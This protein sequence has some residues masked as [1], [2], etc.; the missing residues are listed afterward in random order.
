MSKGKL[1]NPSNE[2]WE[3]HYNNALNLYQEG[4]FDMAA[5]HLHMV[6]DSHPTH[7]GPHKLLVQCLLMIGQYNEALEQLETSAAYLDEDDRYFW[8][9]MCYLEGKDLERARDNFER[10]IAMTPDYPYA[11][12]KLAEILRQSG[13][14]EGALKHLERYYRLFPG[15]IE[16]QFV[17]AE[18]HSALGQYDKAMPLYRNVYL[19][20]PQHSEALNRWLALQMQV[21]MA[22]KAQ[23][24]PGEIMQSI[25]DLA[26]AHPQLKTDLSIK[27][28]YIFEYLD[29]IEEVRKC[30]S[31]AL[32]DPGL[33]DSAG[34]TMRFALLY[35]LMPRSLKELKRNHHYLQK[36]LKKLYQMKPQEPLVLEDLSNVGVY[37]DSASALTGLVYQNVDVL[38]L[39][40]Q[41]AEL[42]QAILPP[43]ETLE[44]PA[45]PRPR[46]VFLL[47]SNSS[48]RAFMLNLLRYF[49][50]DQ[51]EIVLL[52]FPED[53][54]RTSLEQLCPDFTHI[55]LPHEVR[56]HVQVL[57][58]L[59]PDL[60]FFSE[61]YTDRKAQTLLSFFR[62]APVQVTS[63]LSSGSSGSNTMDYYLSSSLLEQENEPQ[64]FYS[65][66]LKLIDEIPGVMK[67][68]VRLAA[69]PERS[70]YGLP[71]QGALY[72][73]TH[74]LYK[75]HPDFDHVLARILET[76]PTG[77]VVVQQRPDTG[78]IIQRLL[79]R[80]EA[81]YPEVMPRIWVLPL[82]Q[83]DDYLGLLQIA[84][85]M[86]DPF[87]FGG[88]TTSYEALAMGLPVVTWPGERLHGRI[89]L[90]Y[91]RK[92]QILD[93]IAYNPENYVELAV[94]LATDDN[95]RLLVRQRIQERVA[96]LFDHR[97]SAEALF[98]CLL[99]LAQSKMTPYMPAEPVADEA[100][101]EQDD[102][103]T[104][105]D[106][107]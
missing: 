107:G 11:E 17:Q 78:N 71:E 1:I 28:A 38:P 58:E 87:Y 86:L 23:H 105:G 66:I 36:G 54:M 85:V 67:R 9:G 57:R 68:P 51:A 37:L 92:M 55:S 32:E 5:L 13:D 46:M 21:H 95:L 42:M 80:I 70:E 7:P 40:K 89:T 64:R 97:A 101:D 16:S 79:A 63:W 27:S 77:H 2:D 100:L 31:M 98:D 61:V 83:H 19:R 8:Y 12:F 73:C 41:M 24:A 34:Y 14:L 84:D 44:V 33:S 50:A 65:E 20:N 25:I 18:V 102:D 106:E 53:S 56:Q 29:E 10:T 103:E 59:A 39:R 76:D 4:E 48:T 43:M 75:L 93:C 69:I 104:D 26:K 35:E 88:G 3:S 47:N 52:Y 6:I 91:Y 90:A 49:P 81:L 82:M 96:V 72:V 99:T 94:R 15:D 30:L 60:L 45:R 74:L 22:H 62:F